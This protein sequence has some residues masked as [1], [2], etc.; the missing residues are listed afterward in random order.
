MTS[1]PYI[2]SPGGRH[3]TFPPPPDVRY[4]DLVRLRNEARKRGMGEIC[5]QL[6]N[7][8]DH[9]FDRQEI[10]GQHGQKALF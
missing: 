3:V 9:F 5:R 8:V 2:I 6:Q 1:L 7:R 10:L 4:G